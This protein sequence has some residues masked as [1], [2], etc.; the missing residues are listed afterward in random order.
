MIPIFAGSFEISFMIDLWGL[1]DLET[2]W[3]GVFATFVIIRPILPWSDW[4]KF[5]IWNG[6]MGSQ[7]ICLMCGNS[8]LGKLRV[9]NRANH[10]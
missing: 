5:S 1:Q 9:T 6:M 8:Y 7:L 3:R 2:G 10:D 4:W